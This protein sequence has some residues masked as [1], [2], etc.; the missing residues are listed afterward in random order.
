MKLVAQIGLLG[1]SAAMAT[2][3]WSD[4]HMQMPAFGGVETFAC[5]FADGK[6]MDD[7]L[8]L[9]KK[10]DAWAKKNHT[11]AY[12]GYVLSPFYYDEM[13]ADVYWVGFS[14]SFED[15]AVVQAEFAEMGVK[16]QA[17]FD[18]I[19]P[20]KSHRQRA[21][22]RVRDE[23]TDTDT[24]VVDFARCTMRPDATLEKMNAA[25]AQMNAFFSEVG[26]TTRIYRWYP[27]QGGS[28]SGADFVQ[29]NWSGSL[30]EKGANADKF[31]QNGGAQ[32]RNALYGDLLECSGGLSAN[33]IRVGGP[34]G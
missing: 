8:Q 30:Q 33:Y 10:W 20:C 16:M 14:P 22:V 25:D 1:L 34:E 21:W 18:S 5:D 6:D 4:D 9:T 28:N 23:T 12:T 15:Q 17:E 11:R 3:A 32:L 2:T 7:L 27:M 31:L 13:Q 24:G 26:S 19:I 29:A